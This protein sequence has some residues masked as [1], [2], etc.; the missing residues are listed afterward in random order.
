MKISMLKCY[1]TNIICFATLGLLMIVGAIVF[2]VYYY[3][4]SGLDDYIML[5]IA[6]PGGL[7]IALFPILLNYKHLTH[8]VLNTQI[9]TS[10]SFLG[11]KRCTVHFAEKVYYAVFYVQFAYAPQIRFIALSN[12]KYVCENRPRSI[13]EKSFY[14]KYNPKKIIVFPYDEKVAPLLHLNDWIRV[15]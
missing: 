14:G 1:K 8:L 11:K 3:T 4:G 7:C 10:Y 9:C 6:V 2:T 13:F 15:N 12:E 5:F